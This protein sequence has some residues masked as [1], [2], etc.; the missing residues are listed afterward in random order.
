MS[1]ASTVET[2]RIVRALGAPPEDLDFLAR[3]DAASLRDLRHQIVEVLFD[4]DAV[5]L[6]SLQAA[7]RMLP[8]QVTA[9]IAE[10]ALGPI[11]CGRV[12][13]AVDDGTA[14]AIA[15]RLPPAFLA[16][17][18]GHVHPH[19]VEVVVGRLHSRQIEAAADVLIERHDLLALGH[20]AGIIRPDAL[21]AVTSR[22]DASQILDVAPYVEPIE[23]VDG[24]IGHLDDDVLLDV[25]RT[26]SAT[27]RWDDLFDLVGVLGAG[28]R[29]RIA[30]LTVPEV[31]LID[32]AVRAAAA[33]DR[34]AALLS[35]AVL[36]GDV[37]QRCWSA[38]DALTDPEVLA[39]AVT[40]A[41]RDD[42]WTALSTLVDLWAEDLRSRV[43]ERL[44]E[45]VRVRLGL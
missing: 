10:R 11:L 25:L 39:A 31:D 14:A 22:L 7:A 40:A 41:R 12:A 20:F 45:S 28:T 21:H 43:A 15:R 2:E 4:P 36:A 26:A 38:V 8:P 27:T 37:P 29:T 30:E 3:L 42:L 32:G 17:V 33:S 34:W 44:D 5:R 23:R 16:D 9:K 35:F 18:A 13:G 19:R 6:G 24:I 1:A